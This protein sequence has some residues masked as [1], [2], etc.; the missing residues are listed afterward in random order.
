MSETFKLN[1]GQK[2]AVDDVLTSGATYNLLYGGSRSG[3]TFLFCK[4]L[5]D[6]ALYAPGSDHLIVRQDGTSAKRAI[7]E[8]TMPDVLRLAF[9]GMQLEWKD[10]KGYYLLE[11]GSRIWVGGLRDQQ[12]LEKLLGNEYASIYKNEASEMTFNAHEILETRLA[13]RVKTLNGGWLSQRDYTDL[14]PTTR[15]HWT[16]RLWREGVHPID[17]TKVDPSRYSWGVINPHDNQEN[18]SGDYLARLDALGERARKRFRDG[19]YVSDDENALWR[20]SW[21]QRTHK[22][23]DESWPVEMRR[24][25]VAI[26]PAVSSEPGSDETGIVAMGLGVDGYGY[27]LAD[28]SGRYRPEEWARRAVSLYQSMDA[29]R[30]I[31]EVNN[32]G[33]LIESTLRTVNANI[34]YKGVRATRGKA[35]RAEPVAALYERGKVFHVGAHSDL[36][37]QMCSVT[38]D[39]D[40][41]AA[42]WSPDRVDALVWAATELFA[43]LTRKKATG[44]PVAPKFSMV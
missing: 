35:V 4:T 18:L 42:G 8:K 2:R 9:S 27:V 25:V 10:L 7:V 44:R 24:I 1:P 21:I 26:D 41:K 31:G 38:V 28:E 19:E 3:K 15:M 12:A 36:E 29:D 37:D 39:F 5:L 22:R 20:R 43:G 32:G 30:I 33:D 23:E 13:Q 11:N 17:E 40:S 6:R 34:P 16:Y 14:N